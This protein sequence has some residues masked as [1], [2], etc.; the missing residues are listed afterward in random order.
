MTDND[1]RSGWGG[2]FWA[3]GEKCGGGRNC[4][5]TRGPMV[6]DHRCSVIT[7]NGSLNARPAGERGVGADRSRSIAAAENDFQAI[8]T[9]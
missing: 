8:I 6:S 7:S 5:N 2:L 1:P 9:C 4:D 3:D